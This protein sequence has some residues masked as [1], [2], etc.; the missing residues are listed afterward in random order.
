MVV[1]K[2]V[3]KNFGEEVFD[4]LVVGGATLGFFQLHLFEA[5]PLQAAQVREALLKNFLCV[6]N[7]CF[8][9]GFGENEVVFE[10]AVVGVGLQL[11]KCCLECFHLA[12]NG[13]RKHFD[14]ADAG[15]IERDDAYALRGG[16]GK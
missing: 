7:N 11:G 1:G 3:A 6:G 9:S 14:V 10:F 15:G 16:F 4:F 12:A 2:A 5:D 13:A 8:V